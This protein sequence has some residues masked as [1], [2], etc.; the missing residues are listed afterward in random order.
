[1]ENIEEKID[2][3]NSYFGI[4][5]RENY[6]IALNEFKNLTGYGVDCIRILFHG[7]FEEW[8]VYRCKENQIAL[9]IDYPAAEKDTIGYLNFAQFY[10]FLVNE[11]HNY[12]ELYP[13]E[14]DNINSILKEIKIK[15]G[16][17]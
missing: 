9:I 11:S 17:N 2:F 3:M 15:F 7:D 14:Y 12:I 8:E 10:S 6:Y 13:E 16:L 1:M 4:V 5:G